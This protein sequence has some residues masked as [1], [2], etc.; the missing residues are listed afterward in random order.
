M[1]IELAMMALE[2]LARAPLS[3]RNDETGALVIE[4]SSAALKDFARLFLLLAGDA[5][6]FDLKPGLHVT[7][8]SP[9]V[10]MRRTS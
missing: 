6:E 9:A 3:I 4:G 10:V 8:G 2:G 5:D 1:N 7:H